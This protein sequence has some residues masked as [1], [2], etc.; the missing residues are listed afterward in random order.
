MA[1]S[2]SG[3]P[4]W[5]DEQLATA[6]AAARSWRGVMRELGL[7]PSNGGTTRTIR[8]RA[9]ALGIKTSHFRANRSWSDTVLRQAIMESSTWDE[10]LAALGLSSRSGSERTLVKAH[11]FRLGL[12][13]GHLGRP[14]PH[15][16]RPSVLRPGLIHL[17]QAAE[18][19]AAAWFRLCGCNVAFPAAPDCYDL[20]VHAPDG[21]KRVQVKT[22]AHNSKNGWMVQ[23]SR[24][25]YSAGNN[26]PLVPYDPDLIDLFFVVDGDLTM[27]V[28]PTRAV[29]GYTQIL[30]RSY[31]KYVVGSAAGFM[32]SEPSAA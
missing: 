17:R 26:A 10:V 16:P 21:L 30:L 28:I 18:S 29:G 2:Q 19:L 8:R 5:S 7:N 22:T 27:Y 24:R 31:R 14:D 12:D 11:A 1:D 3:K 15:A 13:V 9:A 20:L 23:V 4:T 6:I 25:P 32:R